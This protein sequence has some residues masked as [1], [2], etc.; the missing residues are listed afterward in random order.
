MRIKMNEKRCVLVF[1]L[2]LFFISGAV[3]QSLKTNDTG[4]KETQIAFYMMNGK[5]ALIYQIGD[6]SIGHTSSVSVNN[7]GVLTSVGGSSVSRNLSFVCATPAELTLDKGQLQLQVGEGAGL[8]PTVRFMV[9]ATG[10][11]QEWSI[12]PG[13]TGLCVLGATL[14][15][16]GFTTSLLGIILGITTKGFDAGP[17][18]GV[19]GGV[20]GAAGI[21]VIL[22]SRAKATLIRITY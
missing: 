20:A 8:E 10:G 3:S 1:A 18:M 9:S 17:Y 13:R 2:G 21:P 16:A 5:S 4:D 14:S 6:I 11:R 12:R 15:V 19:A 7:K 22:A